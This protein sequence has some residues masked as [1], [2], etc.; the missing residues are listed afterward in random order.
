MHQI[1]SRIKALEAKQP[2]TFPDGEFCISILSDDP[3]PPTRIFQRCLVWKDGVKSNVDRYR[4]AT[5]KDIESWK[6]HQACMDPNRPPKKREPIEF[7]WD[8]I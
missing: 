5:D 4:P 2:K 8:K 7:D 3:E 6:R 1:L